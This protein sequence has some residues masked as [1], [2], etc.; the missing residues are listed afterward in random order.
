MRDRTERRFL[1]VRG[2][3]YD[4]DQLAACLSR[5]GFEELETFKYGSGGIKNAAVLLLRRR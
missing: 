2:K 4:P 1:M 5:L 3:R